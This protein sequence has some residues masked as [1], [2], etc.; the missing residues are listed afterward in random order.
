MSWGRCSVA[1]LLYA[2]C[3]PQTLVLVRLRV[4][5]CC[6]KKPDES[7]VLGLTNSPFI[8]AAL[9]SFL[10]VAVYK[11]DAGEVTRMSGLCPHLG[12]LLQ[13]NPEDKEWNCPCHGSCFDKQGANICGPATIDMTQLKS[14]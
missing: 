6:N 3:L 11:D 5:L 1:H 8:C 12:C 13:W 2:C 7:G 4:H 14:K 10:Q 9:L